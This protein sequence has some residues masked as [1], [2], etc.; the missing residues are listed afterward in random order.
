MMVHFS[1][2]SV[3]F[4]CTILSAIPAASLE[5]SETLAIP[6]DY[7]AIYQV[8]RNNKNIAEVTI[9]LS[10]QDDIWTLHGFTHDMQG[11]ADFLNIKGAQTTTGTW[12]D[13]RFIPEDYKFSFSLIGYKTD[14]H[15]AFDWS[16][17]FVTTYGK[18]GDTQL[19]LADNA[20]DPFSLSLNIRSQLAK[21]QTQMT[22]KIVDEDELDHQ[23]Y[24][25]DRE[26]P[27]DTAL[28]CLK[29]TRVRRIR[30]N[31]KR[32]SMVW[33]A[34]DHNY[35]PVLMQHSKKK[36]NDF[37]LKI[38]SLDVNGLV[39]QPVSPCGLENPGSRQAGL[40]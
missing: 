1:N 6:P 8:L 31:S 12:H 29:T 2:F 35:V 15:A 5:A 21:N 25:A 20:V 40:S 14:W 38:I 23:V 16:S 3:L 33:Y 17:G 4:L 30:E 18:A 9:R 39:V 28:G 36:G 27:V 34:N 22:V 11:L 26:E 7:T 10:H 37:R 13:G 24:E 19:P 32:T